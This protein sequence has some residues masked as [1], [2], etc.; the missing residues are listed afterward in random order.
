MGGKPIECNILAYY[1]FYM[2]KTKFSMGDI[3]IML[4]IWEWMKSISSV[5]KKT[6]LD[7]KLWKHIFLCVY[8]YTSLVAYPTNAG[9]MFLKDF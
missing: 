5:F 6:Y 2:P 4:T 9:V 3:R 8:I 7:C 1:V